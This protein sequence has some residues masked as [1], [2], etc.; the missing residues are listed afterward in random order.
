MELEELKKSWNIFDEHLKNKELLKE[1]EVN[2]LID[3]AGKGIHAIARL[4][5][6]LLLISLP[7]LCLLIADVWFN[8]KLNPVYIIVIVSLIPAFCWDIFTFR[9]LRKIQVDEMPPVEVIGRVNRIHRWMIR[10]RMIAVGYLLLLAMLSFI[11]WEVWQYGAL[12][13][14]FFMF[15]WGGGLALILWVYRKKFLNRIR[16]IKKNLNELKELM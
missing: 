1:E 13:V 12:P 7:I 4:N 8:G 2:K 15:L 5:L 11:Y 10:E 14:L 6:Q 9:F 16:E 3:H